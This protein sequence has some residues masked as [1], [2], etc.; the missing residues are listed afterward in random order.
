[1]GLGVWLYMYVHISI[2]ASTFGTSPQ[3]IH[4]SPL[5]VTALEVRLHGGVVTEDFDEIVTHVVCD[6]RWAFNGKIIFICLM[7]KVVACL[8]TNCGCSYTCVYIALRTIYMCV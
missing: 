8:S 1:M 4:T 6:M 3:A 2:N 5:D 7:D